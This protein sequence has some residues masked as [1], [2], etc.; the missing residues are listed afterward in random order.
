M[1]RPS[2]HIIDDDEEACAEIASALRASG[3]DCSWATSAERMTGPGDR[4]PDIL[5]LD[6][7]LPGMDGF[8]VIKRLAGE[9]R[10][11]HVIVASGQEHRII[12]AA[13]RY[14]RDVG[15]SIL[16]ALEK[17]YSIHSLLA[18]AEKGASPVRSTPDDQAALIDKLLGSDAIGQQARTVFQ[19]KRRL[20]DGS[21]VGYEALLRLSADGVAINP[22]AIFDARIEMAHQIAL[23]RKVLDDALQFLSSLRD[24]GTHTT[25]SVNCTPAILCTGDLPEIVFEALER[26]QMP[27]G[28]LMIEITENAAIESFHEVA[29]AACRLA[30]R[31]CGISIDDFGRGTTSLERLFD[32]PLT[33][34]KID[35]EIF[36]KCFDGYEPSGLLKEVVHYCEERGITSTVEGIE[37]VAHFD[38]ATSLGAQCGQGYLWDWPSPAV[39]LSG[40]QANVSLGG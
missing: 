40:P 38:F 37:T 26:W 27:A 14:A 5:L 6:L 16:G 4:D 12:Q 9:G 18:L 34:L 39:V 20:S 36:W 11:S 15:L 29:S 2:L 3:Y 7:S 35:K 19:S 10:R 17:P 23:T 13:V 32:L 30:M 21:I 8:Q 24:A 31:D 25:V 33:E 28:T 22:E 1:P